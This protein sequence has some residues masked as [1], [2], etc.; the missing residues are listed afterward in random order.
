MT[1]STPLS[2]DAFQ[3]MTPAQRLR[4][5][6]K[7]VQTEAA[8]SRR[9]RRLARAWRYNPLAWILV[10]LAGLVCMA[11]GAW[12]YHTGGKML[13]ELAQWAPLPA[14]DPGAG[15]APPPWSWP[16]LVESARYLWQEAFM[17]QPPTVLPEARAERESLL[18]LHRT[19]YRAYQTLG[20]VLGALG[21]T[22]LLGSL[23]MAA[24]RRA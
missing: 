24:A 20:L 5:V 14:S 6:E 11:V 7:V 18:A 3:S 15:T 23:A 22:V 17:G 9:R 1:R 10:M 19:R 4:Y 8:S 16:R 21:G 12:N 2:H 13:S